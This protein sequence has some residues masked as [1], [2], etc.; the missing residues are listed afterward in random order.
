MSPWFYGWSTP[1][2]V[3]TPPEIRPYEGII[4]HWP[5]VWGGT[6]GLGGVGW[7]A[8]MI[9]CSWHDPT[10]GREKS[11][12]TWDDWDFGMIHPLHHFKW[13]FTR[14]PNLIISSMPPK[15]FFPAISPL[16]VCCVKWFGQLNNSPT[17]HLL[18]NHGKNSSFPGKMYTIW[19]NRLNR[20]SF[21]QS[22]PSSPTRKETACESS[23][24]IIFQ[25][26]WYIWVFPKIEVLQ[27][28]WWK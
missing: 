21:R 13:V 23:S 4:N 14:S 28:G 6:L 2:N 17:N 15:S 25:I 18:V 16:G 20:S 19:Q 22:S 7:P 1:P 8:M 27:N 24:L 5:Y 3:Y 9:A 12:S 26:P 11:F 10:K